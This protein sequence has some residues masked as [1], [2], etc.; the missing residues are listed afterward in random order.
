M[1]TGFA[2]VLIFL[3]LGAVVVFGGVMVP[4]LL[5]PSKPYQD[6]LSIYECGERPM[7]PAWIQF[8]IRFYVVALIFLIFD[9][10]LAVIF[11]CAVVYGN[12]VER[13][14]G[15]VAF[16]EIA[17]FILVLLVG[18]I[19]AW[20]RGDFAWVKTLGPTDQAQTD[21]QSRE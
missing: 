21:R 20:A 15:L 9:V 2:S 4:Y 14:Q 10:E 16:V 6:K 11:P 5:A 18:L 12:W 17:L 3:L 19:Y 7:G 13:G 1:L 8:N